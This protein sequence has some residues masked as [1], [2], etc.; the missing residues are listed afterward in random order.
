MTETLT[1]TAIGR[2]ELLQLPLQAYAGPVHLIDRDDAVIPAIQQLERESLLGFDTETKPV[3]VRG[4]SYPPALVQLAGESAVYIFQLKPLQDIQPLLRLLAK[5]DIRKVG[6]A[7][8]DDLKKLREYSPF[9]PAGFIEIGTLA[10]SLGIQQ[11]GLRPLA[12]LL[13]GIRISKK[14]QRSN[15]ARERL[16]PS[17]ISYAATDAAISRELF[18]RLEMLR[19]ARQEAER[20]RGSARE[21][22]A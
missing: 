7:L 16:T 2:E 9:E 6:V 8:A 18:R 5:P 11:T 17:Q 13:L 3:F 12:G 1:R 21:T 14:E 20:P 22:M 4:Q 10:Q 15:W 19:M